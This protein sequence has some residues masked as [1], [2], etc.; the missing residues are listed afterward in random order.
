M[1]ADFLNSIMVSI[2]HILKIST[3]FSFSE[4]TFSVNNFI[5]SSLGIFQAVFQNE[6]SLSRCVFSRVTVL[7]FAADGK[8]K[9]AL[10][11]VL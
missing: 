6:F 3:F 2:I 8:G 9:W 5:N 7:P 4:H 1:D 10:M 11:H